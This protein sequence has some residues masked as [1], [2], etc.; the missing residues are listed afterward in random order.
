MNKFFTR[1]FPLLCIICIAAFFR[2]YQ[3]G[4]VPPS[5]DW[6]E[7]ALGY[8]AYSIS[9]TGKDEYGKFLPLSIRS[10]DDYKPPLY[11]YLTVP[12]VWLFGLS[13]WS[14]RLPSAVMGILAVIGVYYLVLALL[15]YSINPQKMTN[16]KLQMTNQ[17][18]ISNFKF[19][20][21]F[22]SSFLLAI[23]PWHIQFSRIAFEAN[24]GVTVNIWAVTCFLIGLRKKGF[25]ILSA[26]LFGLGLYAYHSER[27]F[28]PILVLLLSIIFRKELC[29]RNNIKTVLL[30]ICIG[31]I[32]VVPLL[33]VIF[34]KT[35]LMRLEG[36]SSFSNTM[37]L[38]SRNIP[39][40]NDDR[41]R[42]DR[43]GELLDNRRL[44]FLKTIISG[45]LSHFSIKWLFL[46]GDN[47]RHH[48]PDMGLLYMWELPFFLYGIYILWKTGGKVTKLIFGWML[49]APV[50]AAPTSG[51]PH[52]IRT[53]VFLP[54]FQIITAMGILEIVS[55]FKFQVSS[56][57]GKF[58]SSVLVIYVGFMLFNILYYVVQYFF[59]MNREYSEYWQYGYKEAVA[60]TELVKK[61]YKKVVVSTGLEQSYM[62]YLFYT[63]YDP[64]KYLEN[65]GT[66]SGSFAERAN[67]FDTYEFRPIN[68]D[69][70]VFDGTILYVG[71]P[72][73]MP[74][75]NNAH[76]Q[77]LNGK[78]AIE[79][80]DRKD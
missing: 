9:K 77:F 12:S 31:M 41:M 6:D 5:P 49:I 80:K 56:L 16:D 13:P 57:K 32:T 23:S 46:T 64:V 35:A 21:A 51:L 24:S 29:T 66:K 75:G 34:N 44:V 54:M 73:E 72:S 33:S 42:G 48:A 4:V 17:F 1:I 40:I 38:L 52:A 61:N 18:Q 69:R 30:G 39:K 2:L 71:S 45:Y 67:A 43:V 62:F 58:Y 74:H 3:L 10:F 70:E 78:P 27:I 63:K 15:R 26:F 60:Y 53:L 19:Q 11:T 36:T 25:L 59:V 50:A 28:I 47:P 7:A 8:N 14:T 20:I 65:G 76:I 22:L 68:W 37:E 79:I 55:S